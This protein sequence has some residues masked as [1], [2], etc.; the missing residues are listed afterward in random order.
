MAPVQRWEAEPLA[1]LALDVVDGLGGVDVG[2]EL[3][4]FEELDDGPGLGVVVRQ[5]GGQDL[6]RVVGTGDELAAHTSLV[7]GSAGRET[8]RL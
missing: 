1:N 7:S 3:L 4:A 8:I 5:P 2:D 6:E